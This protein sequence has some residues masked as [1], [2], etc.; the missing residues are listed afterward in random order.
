MGMSIKRLKAPNKS[1]DGDDRIEKGINEAKMRSIHIVLGDEGC[2][3]K[4]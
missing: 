2:F 1:V 4:R 3:D